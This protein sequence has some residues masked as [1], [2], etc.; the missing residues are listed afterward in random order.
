MS[1]ESFSGGITETKSARMDNDNV[2][3]F[4]PDKR[5]DINE[6]LSSFSN[7]E[8]KFDP[9]KRMEA[10]ENRGTELGGDIVAEKIKCINESLA[11]NKHSTGIPFERRLVQVGDK[12][13]EVVVPKF[14]SVF[15]AQLPV[16]KLKES[17]PKQ[18][19]ECNEQLKEAISNN[20]ELRGHFDDEQIEQ[21]ENGD[22]PDVYT[23]HHD[24][25]VGK[26]QLVDTEI[27]QKTGHT[28]GRCIWGG[29]NDNR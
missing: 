21:I 26:M 3:R 19:K 15:D 25:E 4:D 24:A 5:M 12:L 11:G 29:G 27:H 8:M 23:W 18:F 20:Q 7:N 2:T 16:D 28:G 14:D 9:D 22:T 1:L 17:D 13:Y 10:N 6:N